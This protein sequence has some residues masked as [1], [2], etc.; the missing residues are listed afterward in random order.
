M[1]FVMGIKLFG[2]RKPFVE[3]TPEF[4]RVDPLGLIER[5]DSLVKT[6]SIEREYY[7]DVKPP[8]WWSKD[9]SERGSYA[10][11]HD[12][13]ERNGY[14]MRE[15]LSVVFPSDEGNPKSIGSIWVENFNNICGNEADGNLTGNAYERI[16]LRL[17]KPLELKGGILVPKCTIDIHFDL[18]GEQIRKDRLPNKFGYHSRKTDLSRVLPTGLFLGKCFESYNLNMA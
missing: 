9:F 12:P 15:P 11:C 7:R 18:G 3:R 4:K 14:S 17:W 1:G 8:K 16:K 2:E 5:L 10:L 6:G 13:D